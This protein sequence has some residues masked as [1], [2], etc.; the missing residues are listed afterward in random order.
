M[1]SSTIAKSG[2]A[3]AANAAN[4][5]K[6]TA[7]L[8]SKRRRVVPF[9]EFERWQWTHHATK[10]PRDKP[11]RS[12]KIVH[13]LPEEDPPPDFGCSLEHYREN[14]A[15]MSDEQLSGHLAQLD[16]NLKNNTMAINLGVALLEA[17]AAR[18]EGLTAFRIEYARR[19]KPWFT[20][21]ATVHRKAEQAV[22]VVSDTDE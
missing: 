19:N 16:G 18:A 14:V 5:A 21:Q 17:Q 20:E 1:L 7:I 8:H 15:R 22:D 13:P 2:A 12:T 3:K 11:E 9:P 10:G 6:L 4:V